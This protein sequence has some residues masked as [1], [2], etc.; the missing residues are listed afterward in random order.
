MNQSIKLPHDAKIG[1]FGSAF[2]PPT[3]GHMSAISSAINDHDLDCVFVTPSASHAF[4][5][6]MAPF[7]DRLMMTQLAVSALSHELQNKIVLSTIEL[8]ILAEN[9]NRPVYSYLVLSKLRET[10]STQSIQLILGPDNAIASTFNRFWK[11]DEISNEFGVIPLSTSSG[12]RSSE[13]RP[14]F[15]GLADGSTHNM[16][17]LEKNLNQDVLAYAIKNKIYS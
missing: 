16:E 10:Y 6:N 5:K 13:C 9:P 17:F 14:L 11:H 15:S 2:N 4:G 7:S 12:A 8:D 1:L 3:L